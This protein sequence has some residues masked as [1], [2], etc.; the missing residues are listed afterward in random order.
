[1]MMIDDE[2]DDDDDYKDKKNNLLANA[3]FT[4][5]TGLNT[6]SHYLLYVADPTKDTLSW[7]PFYK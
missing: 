6:L 7:S 1:M 3:S 4:P 5:V 2:E